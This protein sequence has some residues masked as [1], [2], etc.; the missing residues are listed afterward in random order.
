MSDNKKKILRIIWNY[1]MV[2]AG[3]FILTLGSVIFFTRSELV[4]GGISG[5]SVIIQHLVPDFA[6]YDYAVAI[7]TILFWVLGLFFVGRDFA[8]KTLLSSILYIGFTFLFYRLPYFIHLAEL[9]A[10]VADDAVPTVGNMIL[11]GLFGG[12]FVGAG[13]AITFLGGGST[14]GVDVIQILIKKYIGIKESVSS[15]LVDGIIIIA[16]MIIIGKPVEAA[17]GIIS[18]FATALMV[19]FIYNR[20]QTSYQ[21]DV[22]SEEWEQISRYTQD[23]LLRGATIVHVKGGYEGTDR[24]MLRLVIPKRQYE[25]LREAIA[26]ID[27]KAFVTFT[28]TNAVYGEGFDHNKYKKKTK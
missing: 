12:A 23:V 21:V 26:R 19:E 4:A 16:G 27:S 20:S 2:T 22:I 9:F 24:I 10:G 17:C 18:A 8:L 25:E 6:I 5:I 13:V 3:T 1:I 15:I 28:R 11:C 7:L 14:G